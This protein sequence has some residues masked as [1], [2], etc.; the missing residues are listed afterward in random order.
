VNTGVIFDTR[1]HGPWTRVSKND[2]RVHGPCWSPVYRWWPTRPVNKGRIHGSWI[3]VVCTER[4]PLFAARLQWCSASRGFLRGSWYLCYMYDLTD[5]MRHF[6]LITTYFRRTQRFWEMLGRSRIFLSPSFQ[7]TL[8]DHRYWAWPMVW[9]FTC[10]LLQHI[11]LITKA[12]TGKV[13]FGFLFMSHFTFLTF[14][15]LVCRHFYLKRQSSTEIFKIPTNCTFKKQQQNIF[16]NFVSRLVL[17]AILAYCSCP[18]F[19]L[20]C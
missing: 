16:F 8:W 11:A 9:L 2:T 14:V 13:F 20:R 10:L 4:P 5:C 15:F 1:V 7:W 19:L 17:I 6:H 18:N 3:R 12:Q